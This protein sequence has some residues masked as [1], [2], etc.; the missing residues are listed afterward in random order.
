LNVGKRRASEGGTGPIRRFM[1]L[2]RK[3]DREAVGAALLA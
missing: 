2:A 1:A 3:A